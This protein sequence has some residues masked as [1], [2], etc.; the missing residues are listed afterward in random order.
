MIS[1]FAQL[2]EYNVRIYIYTHTYIYVVV[3]HH[4]RRSK[5]QVVL[6]LFLV[7]PSLQFAG[8]KH[9][10]AIDPPGMCSIISSTWYQCHHTS[11]GVESLAADPE[12]PDFG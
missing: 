11:Q 5:L 6:H 12:G 3:S 10:I 4:I 2:F 8:D 7:L 1:S 9:A